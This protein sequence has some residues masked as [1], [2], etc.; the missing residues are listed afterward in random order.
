M[1]EKGFYNINNLNFSTSKKELSLEAKIAEEK[2]VDNFYRELLNNG[3]DSISGEL[4][5]TDQEKIMIRRFNQYIEEAAAEVGVTNLRPPLLTKKIHFAAPEGYDKEFPEHGDSVRGSYDAIVDA[6][7][8]KKNKGMHPWQIAHY[9]LHEMVHSFSAIHYNLDLE[10]E[11]NYKKIGYDSVKLRDNSS[12]KMEASSLLGDSE[13]SEEVDHLFLAFNEGVTDLMTKEIL[14]K[15]KVDLIKDLEL[16]ESDLENNP[17][18]YHNAI[19]FVNWIMKKIVEKT[20]E[21]REVVWKKFKVGMLTGSI[22]HLREIEKN[23]G[24]GSL[25]LIAKVGKN[26]EDN[27]AFLEFMKNYDK[28]N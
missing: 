25:R 5:K 7:Y 28:N 9:T 17:L 2:L 26:N 3:K 19:Y 16:D 27:L 1:G 12:K 11:F 22:M 20:N 21:D 13:D 24:P 18:E 10:G 8:I 6:A 15:H 23:L 4:F 14:E